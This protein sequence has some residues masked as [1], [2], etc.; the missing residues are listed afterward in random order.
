MG[1]ALESETTNEVGRYNLMGGIVICIY[2]V[3][4]TVPPLILELAK[5]FLGKSDWN[6]LHPLLVMVGLI[7]YFLVSV[8]LIPHKPPLS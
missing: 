7:F 4:A 5:L 6:I 1:H 8:K 3:I 2:A